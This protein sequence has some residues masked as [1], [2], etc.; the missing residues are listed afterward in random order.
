MF[1]LSSLFPNVIYDLTILQFLKT[2]VLTICHDRS[3]LKKT[4]ITFILEK[5]SK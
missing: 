1:P 3:S 2:I 4:V 5:L